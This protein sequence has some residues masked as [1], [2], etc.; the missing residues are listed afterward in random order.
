MLMAVL[1]LWKGID[2]RSS[3]SDGGLNQPDMAAVW[4]AR[5]QSAAQGIEAESPVAAKR[6][7]AQITKRYSI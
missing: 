1:A 4:Q 7:C 6:R 3:F 5:P 2:V